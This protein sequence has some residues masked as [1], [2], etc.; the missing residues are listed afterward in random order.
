MGFF[1]KDKQNNIMEERRIKGT[2]DKRK[3]GRNHGQKRGN[4]RK[5]WQKAWRK[6]I[7]EA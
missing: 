4:M 7:K 1:R 3:I 6:V 5:Y 2:M